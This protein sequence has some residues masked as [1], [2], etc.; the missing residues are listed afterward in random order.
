MSVAGARKGNEA[1][2]TVL[3][4]TGT[5]I[6]PPANNPRASDRANHAAS[7]VNDLTDAPF[8][9][10]SL[11]KVALVLLSVQHFSNSWISRSSEFAFPLFFIHLYTNTLLPSSLY[12]FLT[13][14]IAIVFSGSMGTLVDRFRTRKLDCVRAFIV[15]QKLAT[16]I[17]YGLFC[18]LFYVKNL[19]SDAKNDGR[20]QDGGARNANVWSLL[21]AIV[22]AGCPLILSNVGVSVAVERDW[23]TTISEGSQARL[24]RL[25]AIMRRIDLLTKLLAPLFVSLLTS[26][27]GYPTSCVILLGMSGATA[28]FEIIWI[29]TVY[30]RF[31][32]LKADE[33]RLIGEEHEAIELSS[34][35]PIEAV[36]S[37][38][39]AA[40]SFRLPKESRARMLS[41][42]RKLYVWAKSQALDWR[43]F[44]IMPIFTSSITIALLY[45]SALSFDPQFIAYLKSET[46]YSDAFVAGMRS[47]CVFTGLMGT[48]YAPFS[49]RKIGLVRTGT[50]SLFILLLPLVLTLIA[51]YIGA[52]PE[53]Y[54]PAWNTALLFSG[55]AISRIGLW[56]FDL[57]QLQLVQTALSTHPRRNS[58]MVLQ[59]AM[60]NA[61]DLGHYGLTIGWSRPS[62]LRNAAITSYAFLIVATILYIGVYARRERGHLIHLDRLGLEGLEHLL[63]GKRRHD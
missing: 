31:G 39:Q 43:T 42:Q 16:M 24:S 50:W 55:L 30:H 18:L 2:G 23:V 53:K 45:M 36:A 5:E 49:H 61:F 63:G 11:D 52:E 12:G 9:S 57:T 44:A 8:A 7:E 14:A 25:N 21:A 27:A 58:L 3:P 51:L 41:S 56:S 40:A 59:F 1:E 10:S 60:Q 35:A 47:I 33:D 37:E 26:T 15:A 22:I 29:G 38:A 54:R 48:F 4:S 62:E 28:G 17:S 34:P 32:A 19:Q 20:G 46:T 6:D 13:T